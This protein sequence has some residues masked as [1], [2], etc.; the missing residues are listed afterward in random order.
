[1]RLAKKLY[2]PIAPVVSLFSTTWQ[3]LSFSTLNEFRL[4]LLS[5]GYVTDTQEEAYKIMG[6]LEDMGLLE[7]QYIQNKPE[8]VRRA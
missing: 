3:H 2:N 6:I 1:M 7:I 5:C 4:T 8:K